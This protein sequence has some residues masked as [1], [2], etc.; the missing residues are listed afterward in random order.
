LAVGASVALAF[1]W[2]LFPVRDLWF[3]EREVVDLGNDTMYG[4]A[5]P[6]VAPALLGLPWLLAR[7]RHSPRDR[8]AWL[9]LILALLIAFGGTLRLWSYGRLI[10]HV[11][12]VLQL[13][14][15]DACAALEER[16]ARL[17]RGSVLRHLL[18]PGL[19]GL[20]IAGA[21][22]AAVRPILEE[23]GRG[24][25]LWL[26]FL[27]QQVG[28]DDVVL[29][30]L[31]TCWYVPSFGG[32]VVA[33]PMRL[34]FVPDHDARVGAVR[35]FFERGVPQ[36]E[37]LDLIERFGVAYVLLAKQRFVDWQALLAELQP[38]GRSVYSSPQYELL[39]LHDTDRYSR[40]R[41]T[42]GMR[43]LDGGSGSGDVAFLAA[44]LATWR[45]SCMVSVL[46]P[47]CRPPRCG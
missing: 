9:G 46:P 24:D 4:D 36:A 16:M 31:D 34:P 19:A 12:L 30:D 2:P 1:C 37:R 14:L 21:W 44:D 3:A 11:V 10:S 22:P 13:A 15:A 32:R 38:L 18:A 25:P 5:I 40:A 33:Y 23:A 35:R 7:L 8:L 45:T 41:G 47:G 26:G 42:P 43:I 28:A 6:R 17:R 20:L 27:E 29:T 39:R